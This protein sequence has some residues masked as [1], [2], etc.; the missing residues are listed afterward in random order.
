MVSSASSLVYVKN[1]K[2]KKKLFVID[3]YLLSC[4]LVRIFLIVEKKKKITNPFEVQN[5]SEIYAKE[6]LHY[7]EAHETGFNY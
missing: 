3:P 1:K 5:A 2:K 7:T 6:K 4:H